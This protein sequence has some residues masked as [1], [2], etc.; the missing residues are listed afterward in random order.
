MSSKYN[1]LYCIQVNDMPNIRCFLS[2]QTSP[3]TAGHM[4][5]GPMRTT[6]PASQLLFVKDNTCAGN[7]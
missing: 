7:L 3:D 5:L 4:A 1:V 6:S 2:D